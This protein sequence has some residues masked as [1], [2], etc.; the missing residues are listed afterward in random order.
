VKD[1][2]AL[3]E[4]L[5]A[6]SH[7][8]GAP[9]KAL[10]GS[11]LLRHLNCTLD[12]KG[13]QFVARSF[14]PPPPPVASRV[15]LFYPR[16]GAMVLGSALGGESVHRASLYV[17]S[18]MAHTVALDQGG[19]RKIGIDPTKLK[20]DGAALGQRV[21]SGTIPMLQ[22]GAFKL[23]RIPAIYG[24]PLDKLEKELKIDIDGSIGAGLLASFR[25]TFS[26]GGRVMWVEQQ[27]DVPPPPPLNPGDLSQPIEEAPPSVLPPPSEGL[28]GLPSKLPGT[29]PKGF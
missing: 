6:L 9:I 17:D 15:D 12:F 4:D 3:T 16:G 1:V 20:M 25:L 18:S 2:P 29:N 7:Q 8:I 23:P 14:V 11:N 5:T 28:P 24:A 22:F 19:W 21:R 26:D 27:G 13:R 10:L